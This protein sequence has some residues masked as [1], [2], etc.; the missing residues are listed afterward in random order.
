[1]AAVADVAPRERELTALADDVAREIALLHDA[2]S[3]LAADAQLAAQTEW[4]RGLAA[5]HAALTRL[6]VAA[7]AAHEHYTAAAGANVADWSSVS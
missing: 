2:W 4:D 5:M 1:M 6:R 3:G 7:R